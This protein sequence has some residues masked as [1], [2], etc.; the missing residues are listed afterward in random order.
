MEYAQYEDLDA[1]IKIASEANDAEMSEVPA[2]QWQLLMPH[3][4]E[5]NDYLIQNKKWVLLKL[6]KSFTRSKSENEL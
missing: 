4:K 1:F 6:S 3:M 5:S 2:E